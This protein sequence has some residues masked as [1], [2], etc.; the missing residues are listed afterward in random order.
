MLL[1]AHDIVRIV[2]IFWATIRC[3][4]VCPLSYRKIGRV[5]LALDARVNHAYSRLGAIPMVVH[6]T[7]KRGDGGL[8]SRE[9]V[10]QSGPDAH[11]S[12]G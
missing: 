9:Q 8:R 1:C 2:H 12:A 4:F 5:I 11:E 7:G 3:A 6:V 10:L